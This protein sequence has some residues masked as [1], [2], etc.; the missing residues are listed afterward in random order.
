MQCIDTFSKIMAYIVKNFKFLYV[1][2]LFYRNTCSF[3]QLLTF[4]LDVKLTFASASQY[5]FT[6]CRLTT[7]RGSYSRHDA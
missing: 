1:S 3:S 5:E 4:I 2:V 7:Y 6:A